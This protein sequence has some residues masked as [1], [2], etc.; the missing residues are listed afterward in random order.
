MSESFI[1]LICFFCKAT[2]KLPRSL[3]PPENTQAKQGFDFH[4]NYEGEKK[5]YRFRSNDIIYIC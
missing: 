1:L 5:A 2:N 4:H 3:Q